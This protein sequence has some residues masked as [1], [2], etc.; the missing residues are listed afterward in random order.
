MNRQQMETLSKDFDVWMEN[1]GYLFMGIFPIQNVLWIAW[2]NGAYTMDR[3][4]NSEEGVKDE[5]D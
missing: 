1:E 4:L 5:R 3:M 2:K